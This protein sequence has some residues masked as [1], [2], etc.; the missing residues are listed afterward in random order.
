M[1][2]WDHETDVVVLG[3]G[4]AGLAA[5]LAAAVNG[6]AVEVYE[7]AA[8]VGGTTAV[9]GGIVWVPAHDRNP[10][11]PLP[12]EDAL[13]YLQ[14]QSLGVMDDDLVETFVRTGPVMLEFVEAHSDLRF[15]V[16]EGFPDYK[17]ELPGG[18]PGGGRSLS[19]APFDLKKLGAWHD[20]ITSFPP[21]FSNV[22]IDAETRARIFA[23]APDDIDPDAE[24]CVA[25]TAL[26][27]GLLK[28]LLDAGVAPHTD[29]RARELVAEDGRIVGVRIDVD[30]KPIRVRA[31]RAVV[32]GTG[33]FEWDAGLVEAFLRGP[34]R[35]AVSPPNNT[36][37][38]LRMA[39]A[40]G[41]DLAN[42]G[43]AWWVPIVQIPGDTIDGHPR[44]RSVRLERTRPRSIIVNRAG[45][46]FLNEA[47]EYNSMAGAFQYL[48]P[49]LGY[50]NDPAWIVFDSL[51]LK[52]YGFLGV[53]PDGPVPDWFCAS[54][55]LEELG[56]KTGIDA[57]GLARTLESWNSHV[58]EE[59]DPDFGRGASAYD[60]YWGDPHAASP[61]LQTL[62]PIDTA[63]YYA[64]PVSI[65]AMGTKGGPRTDRD[66]RVLHV[67]GTPIPG[68]YA[69]GNAMAGATGKAYGGAGGTLGPAMVFGVRAGH[70]AATG[71]SLP[72]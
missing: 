28:G 18:R 53:D 52:H 63:P 4:G 35:G 43:E 7:K 60:G 31:H 14:A 70:A 64:V 67:S 9:S 68:L 47:G 36:G 54:A 38:G 10:A 58:A 42:M 25:G 26:I 3:T 44:S 37:D 56:E 33:G 13:A 72:F 61:A 30:G 12:V 5:A 66:G 71:R 48:D 46:R 50:V 16:A 27:A 11:G 2:S 22:G 8:T 1:G 65:G 15:A 29:A 41:A 17:P 23:A 34:M 45:R 6:A 51:H 69:A 20:R 55:D 49:K 19:A 59:R 39:M 40:H 32:L 57:A 24:L 21:D 62:G